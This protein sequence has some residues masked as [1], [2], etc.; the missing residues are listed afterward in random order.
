MLAATTEKATDNSPHTAADILN[1]DF[2][3]GGNNFIYVNVAQQ[4]WQKL[5]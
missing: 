4:I 3:G 1:V 2:L 5:N